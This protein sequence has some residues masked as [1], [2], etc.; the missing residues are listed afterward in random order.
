MDTKDITLITSCRWHCVKTDNG[1]GDFNEKYLQITP[2]D[3]ENWQINF[4]DCRNM[5]GIDMSWQWKNI[6]P[7]EYRT[8][9]TLGGAEAKVIKEPSLPAPC[10]PP[11]PPGEIMC[12]NRRGEY[13]SSSTGPNDGLVEIWIHGKMKF[14]M[15]HIQN[16]VEKFFQEKLNR[17]GK[18]MVRYPRRGSRP[19][20]T[21][22]VYN[23]NDNEKFE[24]LFKNY[25]VPWPN[26]FRRSNIWPDL[27]ELPEEVADAI[28]LSNGRELRRAWDGK[29]GEVIN[30][31]LDSLSESELNR[32]A[33]IC[34]LNSD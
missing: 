29:G 1:P 18:L 21:W 13:S 4:G 15:Y 17:Y 24:A 30:E 14:L 3:W 22:H 5:Y 25:N 6:S 31:W 2:I 7:E 34:H 20:L 8:V 28:D 23:W 33:E 32:V 27:G 9:F 16:I 10:K 19:Y 11:V 26:V 12:L